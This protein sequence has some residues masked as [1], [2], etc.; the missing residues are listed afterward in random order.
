MPET[1]DLSDLCAKA[2]P[3]W[4]D[5]EREKGWQI[6]AGQNIG[7]AEGTHW[8]WSRFDAELVR[9]R[10]PRLGH[11]IRPKPAV[12]EAPKSLGGAVKRN[13]GGFG[14]SQR[15]VAISESRRHE[16]VPDVPQSDQ[17][18]DGFGLDPAEA[19]CTQVPKRGGI[20]GGRGADNDELSQIQ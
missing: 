19:E 20:R 15:R 9:Q 6:C 4:I 7:Q 3:K 5:E 11:R 10:Q 1:V 17:K 8:R 18:T 12:E 2:E 14:C 13:H 16:G